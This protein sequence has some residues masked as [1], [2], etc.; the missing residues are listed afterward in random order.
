MALCDKT[1]TSLCSV[2]NRG[3]PNA[4]Q[5]FYMKA[6]IIAACHVAGNYKNT[7]LLGCQVV[8]LGVPEVPCY[9]SPASESK[10]KAVG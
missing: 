1:T 9:L 3:L 6:K 2:S 5:D 4:K 8:A 10:M 7:G